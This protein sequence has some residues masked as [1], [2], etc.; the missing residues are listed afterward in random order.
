MG[1]GD[2]MHG[3]KFYVLPKKW[4]NKRNGAVSYVNGGSGGSSSD[5]NK[6]EVTKM[7]VIE[8]IVRKR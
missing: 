4:N 1:F 3:A 8:V 5:H 6:M 7:I 2:D